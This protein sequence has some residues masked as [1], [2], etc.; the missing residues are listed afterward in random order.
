MSLCVTRRKY[1][2]SNQVIVTLVMIIILTQVIV[3]LLII[4]RLKNKTK[5]YISIYS[6]PGDS[7][8]NFFFK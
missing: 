5:C 1:C 4:T 8:F 3:A 2:F 6:N 7:S